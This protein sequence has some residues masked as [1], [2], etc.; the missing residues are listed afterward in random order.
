[1]ADGS[2]IIEVEADDKAAEKELN[3]LSRK[4]KTIEAQ[5]QK[6][7]AARAPLVEQLRTARKEAVS[8]YNEVERLQKELASSQRLTSVDAAPESVDPLRFAQELEKQERITAELKQQQAVV[9]EKE[10]AAARLEAQEAKLLAKE[11]QLTAELHAQEKAAG[12]IQRQLIASSTQSMDALKNGAESVTEGFNKSLKSLVKYGLGIRTLYALFGVLRRALTDGMKNL[13]QYDAETNA[14]LSELRSSLSMLKNSLATAFAPI[15]NVVAPILT[16]FIN[17]L[18]T[19]ASYVS[20]FF[21]IL[22]GGSTYKKA[23]AVQEDYADSL[24]N[25]AGA[26]GGAGAAAKEAEKNFSG[27]DEI[28]TWQ[29]NEDTGGGGGGGAAGAGVGAL[30]EDAAIDT[31]GFVGSLALSF[32]DVFLDWTD[33]TGEQI[34]EKI[35]VGLGALAGG[36]IGFT[37][38]GP[39]GAVIGAVIGAGLGLI[40]DALIFD[41]DGALSGNEILKSIISILALAAGGIIGFALGGPGGTAIGLTIGFGIAGFVAA[42]EIDWGGT[43]N[44]VRNLRLEVRDCGKEIETAEKSFSNTE[45]SIESTAVMAEWYIEKLKELEAS[46]VDTAEAHAQYKVAVDALNE[47]LP[48]LN[49]VIDEETCLVEGGTDAILDQVDAWKSLAIQEALATRYKTELQAWADATATL[50]EQE[51]ELVELQEQQAEIESRLAEKYAELDLL[52]EQYNER[53][54][55]SNGLFTDNVGLVNEMETAQAALLTEISLMNTELSDNEA[56]QVGLQAEMER[57]QTSIDEYKATV[58]RAGEA[59][60]DYMSTTAETGAQ[61]ENETSEM[62]SNSSRVVSDM[63][64]A[65]DESFNSMKRNATDRVMRM[66][67]S[68]RS[69]MR[70]MREDADEEATTMKNTTLDIFDSI[71]DG[72]TEKIQKAQSNVKSSIEKIKSFFNFSWSLP[73]IKTPHFSWGSKP[74]S[75]WIASVL[76]ALGLPTSL[77]KLNVSW[78]ARGGIVDGATLFGAGEAGKEAVIPLERHTEWIDLVASRIADILAKVRQQGF[79]EVIAGKLDGISAA[80]YALADSYHTLPIPAVATGTVVPPRAFVDDSEFR[81]MISE[82]KGLM[83]GVSQRKQP[84]PTYNVAFNV[85]GRTLFRAVLKEGKA[86]QTR[87]GE[88]PFDL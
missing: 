76:S 71:R 67:E 35:V 63:E 14:S 48:D 57:S 3:R 84:E 5:L 77:P 9:A 64:T 46:G 19:A 66:H 59:M 55:S 8:A 11:E 81:D 27:L 62:A 39:G 12:A 47:L 53:I 15:L 23:I 21:A 20:M 42:S 68:T 22:S 10:K 72:M 86:Q 25:T 31:S 83:S 24:N 61:V 6:T 45:E 69:S 87:T 1:M 41:H 16:K 85:G 4:I 34:L 38:G 88:N 78:Y 33:L 43:E 74:A 82:L 70:G 40:A 30:F 58:E 60:Y 54:S 79:Y 80:I 65:V 56:A 17:M 29:S 18:A 7:G 44:A 2:V 26:A 36:I 52:T 13:V 49:I 37:I 51:S 28:N 75:G 73:G 50:Y 32:K